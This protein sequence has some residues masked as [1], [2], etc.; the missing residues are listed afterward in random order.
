MIDFGFVIRCAELAL[1]SFRVVMRSFPIIISNL[2]FH[3]VGFDG[4]VLSEAFDVVEKEG[5]IFGQVQSLT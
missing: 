2:L 1:D 3:L 5:S 4:P